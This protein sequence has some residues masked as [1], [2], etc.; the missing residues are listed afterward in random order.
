MGLLLKNYEEI[1][2]EASR[3]EIEESTGKVFIVFEVTNE[4][5]KS[6]IKQNWYTDIEFK[7]KDKSLIMENK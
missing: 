7:I 4:K 1:I 5:Y 3:V 2:A 6:F